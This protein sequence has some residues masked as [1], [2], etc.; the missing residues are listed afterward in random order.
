M[1]P[2]A[3]LAPFQSALPRP[4][5]PPAPPTRLHLTC[6]GRP[7]PLSDGHGQ[8][9]RRD[10]PLPRQPA[11]RGRDLR[12]QG[13]GGRLRQQQQRHAQ[14]HDGDRAEHA[15]KTMG[16]RGQKVRAAA[17]RARAVQ[18]RRRRE[19][20]GAREPAQDRRPHHHPARLVAER[21]AWPRRKW[22]ALGT[23]DPRMPGER[24]EPRTSALSDHSCFPAPRRRSAS[25]STSRTC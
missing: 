3:R 14:A 16:R 18:R 21:A 6:L 11:P 1:A 10:G 25:S 22:C 7:V 2:P 20:G 8:D 12:G 19:D 23:E 4:L 5:P 13:G 9:G 24:L 17:A 15:R